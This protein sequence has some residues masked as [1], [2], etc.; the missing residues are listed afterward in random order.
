MAYLDLAGFLMQYDDMMEFT[1]AQWGP[2][3]P[4]KLYGLGFKSVNVGKTQISGIEFSVTGQGKISKNT[5]NICE[6][7]FSSSVQQC[8]GHYFDK[9]FELGRGLL[10]F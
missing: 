10:M 5:K 3:D 1:F 8:A 2:S 7:L 4:E 6:K 9:L